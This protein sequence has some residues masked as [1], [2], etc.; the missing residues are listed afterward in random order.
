MAEQL[1]LSNQICHRLYMANNAITRAYKPHLDELGITYPQYIVM[2]SLWQQDNVEVGMIRNQTK[3]D[4]GAL[5]QILKK[6]EQKQFLQLMPSEHDKRSKIV[7]LTSQGRSLKELAID[8]PAKLQC[9]F[10]DVEKE[11]LQQLQILLDKLNA[12]LSSN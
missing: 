2:M 4:A 6:L 11:D 7:G 5:T 8:I 12:S 10:P 1:K 9:Q 3:I